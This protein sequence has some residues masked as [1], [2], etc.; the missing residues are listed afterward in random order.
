MYG[1]VEADQL[2]NTMPIR[3]ELR[4]FYETPEYK[5]ARKRLIK[6]SGNLCERCRKP[7][8]KLVWV[9]STKQEGQ[10]WS[11][12]L[13]KQKWTYCLLGVFGD[14]LQLRAIKDLKRSRQLRRIRVVLCAAHLDH[15]P[16]NNDD[17][18]IWFL[19][20]WCH[21]HHDRPHH[22]ETRMDR[23]DRGRPLLLQASA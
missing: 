17:E 21:L 6:R 22:K 7:N 4:H 16:A 14:V 19:C 9:R 12:H 13:S 3:P 15:N 11:L 5:A 8:G 23:K 20:Q 10:C 1:A 18:N 2:G